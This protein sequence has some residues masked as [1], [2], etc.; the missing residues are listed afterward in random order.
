M[1]APGRATWAAIGA[2]GVLAALA[3]CP[4]PAPLAV[5]TGG[6]AG[7]S[8]TSSTTAP[9]SSSSS[10][11][12]GGDDGG[13]CDPPCHVWSKRFGSVG[14]QTAVSVVGDTAGGV[15][16]AGTFFGDIDLGTGTKSSA[17]EQDC[18]VLSL[19]AAG[20]SKWA[21]P[22]GTGG[23]DVIGSMAVDGVGGVYVTGNVPPGGMVDFG[24]GPITSGGMFL[25]KLDAATG[26]HLWH[27][28]LGFVSTVSVAAN[29]DSV[30]IAGAL[31]GPV[32]L[33]AG[34]LDTAGGE[35]VLVAK[36]DTAGGHQW[37][38]RFGGAGNQIAQSVAVNAAG[39][40]LIGGTY[41][42]SL[43]F[44]SGPLG[45]ADATDG[46]VARFDTLANHVWSKGFGGPSAD[47]CTAVAFAPMGEAIIA[48]N[49]EASSISFPGGP[50]IPN[51]GG[52]D[53]VVAKFDASGNHVYSKGYGDA[54]DQTVTSVA[55][56]GAGN[57]LVAGY[58]FGTMNFGSPS[59]LASQG[60]YD[61]FVA[62][63][64]GAGGHVWSKAFGD[65]S[66]FQVANS[67]A[68]NGAGNVLVA[69][70]FYG[71]I[72]FGGGPLASMGDGDAFV[73]KFKP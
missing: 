3:G 34:P 17:G 53:I 12:T 42:M 69:G 22:F 38:T 52:R 48:G 28:F 49:Y 7:S 43:D 9:S 40:V 4:D 11:G 27:K 68:V 67:V 41:Q 64:D 37:S 25:L 31:Y 23:Y 57:A 26:G 54:S 21:K 50:V 14:E 19:D 44:G 72:D 58:F 36:F 35:D 51:V 2:G 46:F 63:L 15:F 56:D 55:V 65:A 10:S 8:S 70:G 60:A 6:G 66:P 13:V 18:F 39:D 47:G 29:A 24:A 16:V 45:V 33:G 30:V 61:V 5:T 62:K 59:P 1:R 73:A 71:N 32:D 20:S